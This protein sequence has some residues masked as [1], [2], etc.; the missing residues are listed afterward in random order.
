[1]DSN[2]EI[3]TNSPEETQRFG[4]EFANSLKGGEVLALV[5][6]LGSGKTTFI[7]GLAKGL[8]IKHQ[9]IS[10]TF[11][12]MREYDLEDEKKL[13]HI[14]LYRLEEN[15]ARELNN[16]GIS[17]WW[18]KPENIVVIEWA[19]KAKGSMPEN[20]IWITFEGSGDQER[21]IKIN[22]L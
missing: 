14:D 12:L 3:I 6:D 18:Q 4:K 7:Q 15:I 20:T 22:S 5:G 2:M 21:K 11:I 10:P 1:M 17:D 19:D 9:I 16:L 13:Y 8:K